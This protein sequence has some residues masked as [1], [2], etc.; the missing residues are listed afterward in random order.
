[1][2]ADLHIHTTASDGTY[3]PADVVKRAQQ[4]GIETIG[5]TDHDTVSGWDE[6][7][8]AAMNT[9][10]R[11]LAG[12][13]IAT[14]FA[15]S[16]RHLLGYF[17][18]DGDLGPLVELVNELRQARQERL[19]RMVN[20]L[21]AAGLR[22]E[23]EDVV[24]ESRGNSPGRPHAARVLVANGCAASVK[25]AFDLY[26]S[27][28]K[29]GYVNRKKPPLAAAIAIIHASGGLAVLAHP[30]NT[31]RVVLQEMIRLGLDGLEVNHP[32]LT[33]AESAA[34]MQLTSENGLIATGGSDF[35]DPHERPDMG[36][37]LAPDGAVESIMKQLRE[38]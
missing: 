5:L 22:I 11:V 10:V 38:N 25:D 17:R 14:S 18:P 20:Q 36:S 32:D 24:R 2:V 37:R 26:L 23:I 15:D 27:P 8:L 29:P 4:K 33:E 19:E 21:K 1:V 13:E 16:E 3:T 7:L 9:P 28:G 35:H 12:V 34:L 6:A 30:R 31:S